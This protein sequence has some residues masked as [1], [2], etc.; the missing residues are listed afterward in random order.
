MRPA[1]ALFAAS[2]L[3]CFAC[4][5]SETNAG[6]GAEAAAETAGAALGLGDVTVLAPLPPADHLDTLLGANG[7]L[8][9]A[10]AS[11]IGQLVEQFT[12]DDTRARL[13]AVCTRF[14]PCAP[15]PGGDSHACIG[16]MRLVFQPL[17]VRDGGLAAQDAAVHVF[18]DL[19]ATTTRELARRLVGLADEAPPQLLGV[20]ARLARGDA[21]YASAFRQLVTDL[22]ARGELSRVTFLRNVDV[23]GNSWTFGGF[24][25]HAGVATPLANPGVGGSE[26]SVVIHGSGPFVFSLSPAPSGD[27]TLGLLLDP[28]R[29][30]ILAD[31]N[32]DAAK[33]RVTT[34][35]GAALA[36][37]NPT[38]NDASTVDCVSC[39]VAEA[40]RVFA[41][42]FAARSGFALDPS[43]AFSADANPGSPAATA[44]ET[45]RACGYVGAKAVI[46]QR[47][48]NESTVAA[49][50]MGELGR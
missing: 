47:T 48:V 25:L 44:A 26:Q 12:P 39:H 1:P 19:D 28:T 20:S 4:G 42:D 24:D 17:L 2:L 50:K 40:A 43:S 15:K 34:G 45:L 8:P 36:L 38:K 23:K 9:D 16:E 3:V 33:A 41:Q 37:E 18:Y 10:I 11:E 13:R 30:E 27:A 6:A 29:L 32:P 49:R 35:F 7:I 14:D 5:R 46:S 22:A 21:A 31:A